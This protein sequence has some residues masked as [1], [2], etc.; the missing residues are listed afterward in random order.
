MYLTTCI[1]S[2]SS[3]AES[4]A[5]NN[6]AHIVTISPGANL[7]E[8]VERHPR[9]TTFVIKAGTYRL[10]Q[11]RPKVGNSFIGKPGAIL[12]GA[13][14]IKN[15]NKRG[16]YWIADVVL[17]DIPQK[18]KCEKQSSGE[19]FHGCR[20]ANDVFLNNQVLI[21]VMNLSKLETGK[22]FFNSASSKVYLSDNPTGQTIEISTARNAFLGNSNRI[23]IRNLIIEKYANP[24]QEGAI[25][26]MPGA[27][28]PLGRD[29][30]I[31]G[32]EIRLNHGV[33]IRLGHRMKITNN[34]V[35]HNGQL[36]IGGA[37]NAIVIEGN[38]IAYN[39]T[40]RFDSHWEAGGSKFSR[41]ANLTV[42]SNYVHHNQG[43]GLWTDGNNIHT[44]YEGNTVQENAGPGI[45]HE[46]SYEA[47]IKHNIVERNGFK[48]KKW[49]DGAGILVTASRDVE[50][51]GN[52]VKDNL[53]GICATQTNRGAGKRGPYEINNLYVHD[54][55]ITMTTGKTGL[56]IQGNDMSY[57]SARNNRFQNNHYALKGHGEVKYFRWKKSNLTEKGWKVFGQDLHGSFDTL[58]K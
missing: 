12:S 4:P 15:F 2:W 7:Q 58:K 23:T 36:G 28:G 1:F 46:I 45:F 43:P 56:D 8:M 40:Q 18:G 20:Q 42:R 6:N 10:Q 29:W 25:Q 57:F 52:T 41:T 31:V 3:I 16:E 51:F 38:E 9:G 37:G 48:R 33:G 24:A 34:N 55:R 44:L 21:Q 26:P 27:E 17:Q 39:N 11:I 54:N 32:N 49:I 13:T 14:V 35:H 50:I 30:E 19:L 53:H 22:W 5:Q 47:V